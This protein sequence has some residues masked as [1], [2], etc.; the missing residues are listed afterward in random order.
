M[1]NFNIK[2]MA[3]QDITVVHLTS[4]DDSK[5][6][7]FADADEQLPLTITIFGKHSKLYRNWANESA[8]KVKARNGKALSEAEE[9]A[10]TANWLATITVSMINFDMDGVALNSFEAYKALYIS[11][12]YSW[13]GEQV[14]AG[15]KDQE[16]FLLK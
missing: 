1:A 15:L 2:S 6:P 4:L 8:R 14:V 10:D 3:L 11:P 7:L 13:I 5:Q 9:L 16:S 12:E